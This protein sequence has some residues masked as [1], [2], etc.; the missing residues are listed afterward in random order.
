MNLTDGLQQ[1]GFS[2]YEARAYAALVA[3]PGVS[4]Y[5]VAKFSGVPRAKIYEALQGLVGEG[6]VL[7]SQEGERTLYHPLPHSTL[8]QRYRER[9]EKV[10]A[11]VKAALDAVATQKAEEPLITVRG[12]EA[13]IARAC[14]IIAGARS[15]VFVSGWTRAVEQFAPALGAAEARGVRVFVLVHGGEPALPV[16]NVYYHPLPDSAGRLTPL[17]EAFV[18]VGDHDEVLVGET[19]GDGIG[20]WTRNRPVVVVA[21]EFIKH[22]IMVNEMARHSSLLTPEQMVAIEKLQAMWFS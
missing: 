1:M 17:T 12:E 4:G 10:A 16:P 3:H 19:T 18:V 13:L 20:L 8:V 5:E 15:R 2:E 6:A 22:D 9:S 14:E 21:A 11:E 7:T